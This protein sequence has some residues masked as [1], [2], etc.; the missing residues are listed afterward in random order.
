MDVGGTFIKSAVLTPGA[1]LLKDSLYSVGACSD[2]SREEIIHALRRTIFHGL[3]C[4]DHSGMRL[5]GIGAAFPGPF[6]HRAGVSLMKHKFASITGVNLSEVILETEGVGS[7][8]PVRFMHDANAVLLGEMWH[9][10]A[11]GFRST[12]L[13]TLGTGLGFAISSGESVLCNE[14][15]GPAV[16]I[17]MRPC[18]DGILEDYV[19]G[20]GI[21]SIYAEITGKNTV[22][23]EAVD[24]GKW[25]D[26]GD[27]ACRQAFHEAGKILAENLRSVLYDHSTECL[28]FGGQVSRSFHHMEKAVRQTLDP[29]SGLKRITAV[30]NMDT[31]AFFGVFRMMENPGIYVSS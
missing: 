25:A 4:I 17:Y 15:G 23:L 10:N 12:A 27:S 3:D 11:Q 26:L 21:V 6:D 7:G 16:T 8:I 24:I 13:V 1:M 31:A 22:H 30:Q 29:V 28:L 20:R 9:G 14:Q 2:G 18:R 19:S 5:A